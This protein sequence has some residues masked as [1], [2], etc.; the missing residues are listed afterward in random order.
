M[1]RLLAANDLAWCDRPASERPRFA[2]P[3]LRIYQA[4]P[5]TP[6]AA[7]ALPADGLARWVDS[8]LINPGMPW[9][10]G[11]LENGERIDRWSLGRLAEAVAVP[12]FTRQQGRPPA[13]SAEALRHYLPM[14]GDTPDRDEAEPFPE[15]AGT[16]PLR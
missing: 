1:L 11:E 14:P 13:S 4:D 2:E 12:L 15:R 5:S 9:R 10:M 8:S 7:Q 6:P 16:Q 3:R